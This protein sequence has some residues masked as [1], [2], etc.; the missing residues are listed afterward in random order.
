M[1]PKFGG[2]DM[3]S[4]QIQRLEKALRIALLRAHGETDPANAGHAQVKIDA[5]EDSEVREGVP[6]RYQA[7]QDA[8][9]LINQLEAIERSKGI[10]HVRLRLWPDS[11]L[12]TLYGLPSHELKGVFQDALSQGDSYTADLARDIL[13]VR[14]SLGLSICP[15][16]GGSGRWGD[17]IP[18]GRCGG[19]GS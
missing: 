10:E 16:C 14:A 5:L 15:S 9:R 17:D 18:C 13:H 4:S 1:F 6:L 12:D 7:W 11:Y 19:W 8:R 3:P 2:G